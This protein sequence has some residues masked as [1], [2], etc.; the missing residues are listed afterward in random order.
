MT[1]PT[2][3]RRRAAIEKT[4]AER[5]ALTARGLVLTG[6]VGSEA[7]ILKGSPGPAERSGAEL[8]SGADGVA[9]RAALLKLGYAPESW[10]GM[11]CWKRDGSQ[12]SPDDLRLAVATLGPGC[13]IVED[14]AAA[15]LVRLTFADELAALDD[16]SAAMLEPGWVARILGMRVMALGGFEEALADDYEKRVM[17][18]RLKGVPSEGSPY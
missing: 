6:Y 4:N 12:A 1:R 18:A 5:D 14:E 16:F 11:A 17:W 10:L 7:M 9:L 2:S 15:D 8:L 13:L 3:G